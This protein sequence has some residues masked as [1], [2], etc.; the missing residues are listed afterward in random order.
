VVIDIQGLFRIN[1]AQDIAQ[2]KRHSAVPNKAPGMSPKITKAGATGIRRPIVAWQIRLEVP[3]LLPFAS[4]LLCGV[5]N[6]YAT[7]AACNN[8]VAARVPDCHIA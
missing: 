4:V 7:R 1:V 5:V 3:I 6:Q 8:D 2:V